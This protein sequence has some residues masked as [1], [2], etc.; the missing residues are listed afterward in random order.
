M[1][2]LL[3]AFFAL[4]LTVT[5]LSCSKSQEQPGRDEGAAGLAEKT[6]GD[7]IAVDVNSPAPA[8]A[9][10]VMGGGELRLADH[11]GKVVLLE[12]WSIFCKSCL[13]EMP[14]VKELHKRYKD[15]G[16]EVVSVNTDAFT[17]ARVM[18]VL[19]KAGLNFDYPVVRDIRREVSEAYNVQILPVTVVIDRNGWIRLYQEGYAPGEEVRF[20]KAIEKCLDAEQKDDVT[21]APRGGVTRFAPKGANALAENTAKA[22]THSRK[23]LKGREVKIG[24][25]P[26]ALFFWSLYCQPCRDELPEIDKFRAEWAEKGV[27]FIA[28]NVD[29]AKLSDRVLKFLA[30]YPDFDCVNDEFSDSTPNLS[31]AY[32]IEET[33][34][35]VLLD[36]TGR[37]SF[38]SRGD[39][40][41]AGLGTKIRSLTA[42]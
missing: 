14:S 22:D 11:V 7:S 21:L 35:V 39:T 4:L 41:L 29:S 9:A 12:F 34:S 6:S 36:A 28:I 27:D 25:K 1:R 32:G 31:K 33:P 13:Q 2:R 10:K 20:A 37:V 24:D 15:R 30:P 23:T 19:Q 5:L 3:G 40:D 17:D 8:F 18:Q 38:V 26:A 42:K 16:F